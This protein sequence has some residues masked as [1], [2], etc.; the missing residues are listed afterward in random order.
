[1][2]LWEKIAVIPGWFMFRSYCVWR[3]LLDF[4]AGMSGDL[5]EIGVWY[6]RSASVLA[7]YRK[8][9]EKLY[10]CDISLEETAI[11]NSIR[12]TGIEP[13]HLVPLS[14]SSADLPPILDLK[15]MHKTVR[16]MHLDGEHTGG[17]VFRELELA[18]R[19]VSD[20][21]IVAIDDFFS[22]R[23][24]ANTTEAIRYLEKNPFHFRLLAVGF[25]KGYLCRPDALPFYMDFLATDMS[26]ALFDYG[27]K[28]TLFKTTG[29][30][31]TDAVGITDYVG[32]SGAIA[33]PDNDPPRWQMVRS[34]NVWSARRR[35]AYRFTK[36]VPQL[37]RLAVGGPGTNQPPAPDRHAVFH[38]PEAEAINLARQEHLASLGL[39]LA[40]KRVLEVGAGIGLH[41]SFFL[42]RGC[43]VTV[44]DARPDNVAEVARRLPKV[45][46]AV[47]D[48]ER[49][50]LAELG[51]FDI[52]Y[53]YGLLYHLAHPERALAKM[54][55]VCTGL[56]LLETAV[57]PGAFDEVLLVRDVDAANQAISGFGC[58]PTRLWVLSR[59]K[60]LF[61]HAYIPLTQPNFV[62]FPL[63]WNLT[64]TQ[65]MHRSTFVASRAPLA[66][67]MLG[68]EVPMVQQRYRPMAL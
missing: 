10:L 25:N 54:A 51:S 29:P 60:A 14:C 19:I 26:R 56:L 43:E 32:D 22:P 21:G 27:L 33:G 48:L 36:A 44:T 41:T 50:S 28:A 23:Y 53:C 64:P 8:G 49:D 16:W 42:E 45:R 7:N 39:D 12:S 6:G 40:G 61:G 65:L 46:T 9:E 62:D 5:F 20:K 34:R 52:V 11:R 1:M 13:T 15:A 67:P 47:I 63:D 31:D 66:L 17:A 18:N 35:A 68:E 37:L 30:W 58:R 55:E 2:L 38:T 4:Q 3:A 59:L 57:S 24:P